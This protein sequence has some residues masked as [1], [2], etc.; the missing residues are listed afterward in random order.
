MTLYIFIIFVHLIHFNVSQYMDE[1]IIV[2]LDLTIVDGKSI[3]IDK[4]S[5]RQ[6]VNTSLDATNTEYSIEWVDIYEIVSDFY[7]FT[8]QDDFEYTSILKLHFE[9]QGDFNDALIQYNTLDPLSFISDFEDELRD[10]IFNILNITSSVIS[11]DAVV[12]S[13][14]IVDLHNADNTGTL[15]ITFPDYSTTT[16]SPTTASPTTD[17]PTTATP[18]T[19]TPTAPTT[20]TPTTP[21]PTTPSPVIIDEKTPITTIIIQQI[22]DANFAFD[23]EYPYWLLLVLFLFIGCCCGCFIWWYCCVNLGL[24]ATGSTVIKTWKTQREEARASSDKA[25][26]QNSTKK[27]K[28]RKKKK[29]SSREVNIE[30]EGGTPSKKKKKKKRPK[31]ERPRSLTADEVVSNPSDGRAS[32]EYI[33]EAME[34]KR[35]ATQRYIDYGSDDDSQ[36]ED[37]LFHQ[38]YAKKPRPESA[39]SDLPRE[40]SKDSMDEIVHKKMS[41]RKTYTYSDSS[42]DELRRKKNPKKR[43]KNKRTGVVEPDRY[44][45]DGK[46]ILT[47]KERM[48]LYKKQGAKGGES[49]ELSYKVGGDTPKG[50]KEKKL[51][52]DES[53]EESGLEYEFDLSVGTDNT[54]SMSGNHPQYIPE[55]AKDNNK[56]KKLDRINEND[57]EQKGRGREKRKSGKRFNGPKKIRN[58]SKDRKKINN[59]NDAKRSSGPKKRLDKKH[60]RS[61]TA[62]FGGNRRGNKSPV[63]KPR[64]IRVGSD[65]RKAGVERPGS[66]RLSDNGRYSNSPKKK[67]PQTA[68]TGGKNKGYGRNGNK[69]KRYDDDEDDESEEDDSLNGMNSPGSPTYG[70]D[71]DD[72]ETDTDQSEFYD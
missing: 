34:A 6:A 52:F 50:R 56:R 65:G 62:D 1:S 27:K 23:E 2:N 64:N 22:N 37:K 26:R 41:H 48:A 13:M 15:L 11:Y 16:G 58:K 29:S 68:K 66:A 51:S 35:R 59:G 18:T 60:Q 54:Q 43:N 24:G 32:Q 3:G 4:T 72:E 7:Y 70:D 28:R 5:I 45:H 61:G 31:R 69:K 19:A 21:S 71:F 57:K 20:A 38:K 47:T 44:D 63:K 36:K 25:Q 42:E 10:K 46:R 9:R 8:D 67:R 12:N 17:T 53:K 14:K 40:D 49:V 33:D 39:R 55:P 30:I